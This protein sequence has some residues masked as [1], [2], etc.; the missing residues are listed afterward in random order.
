MPLSLQQALA[1]PP[2]REDP[3]PTV[4]EALDRLLHAQNQEREECLR[5]GQA[6]LE[7]H[8]FLPVGPRRLS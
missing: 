7:E 4:Q 8:F 2:H 5:A 6:V 1:N 3:S